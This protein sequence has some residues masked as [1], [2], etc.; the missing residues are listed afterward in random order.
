AVELARLLERGAERLLDD[1]ADL[2]VLVVGELAVAELADDHGEE[3]RR[4]REVERAVQRLARFLLE[5]AELLAQRVVDG[6][7]VERA[8]DVAHVLEQPPEHGGVGLAPR[9][10]LDRFLALL[11]VVLVRLF[12][13]RDADEV[14][15]LGQRSVVGE[16]VE[17]RQQFAPREI[18]GR[19]EDHQRGGRD[20]LALEARRQRV[21]GLRAL[22]R[23]SRRYSHQRRVP[24]AFAP[25]RAAGLAFAPLRAA[26]LAFAAVA[27]LPPA[28]FA[29]AAVPEPLGAATTAWPPN[30]LR[31][32]ESTL[33]ANSPL[34]RE[35]KRSYREAVMTGV[36][37]SWSVASWI[38]QRPSP[39]SA[40]Q[41]SIA[42]RSFP[43][44][45][46]ARAASSQSH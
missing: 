40:V 4:G 25:L 7:F 16:V 11:A 14:E 23:P 5:R 1:A 6:V 9:E 31:S 8:G 12:F 42:S 26:G 34:P 33:S 30:W 10:A 17:R 18:A 3:R 19:A 2:R 15:A 38:V 32:A 41:P 45:S 43:S 29:A 27:G 44:S 36:G 39:E 24:P 46:K 13:A 35:R 37:T 21:L 20:R 28:P 22:G